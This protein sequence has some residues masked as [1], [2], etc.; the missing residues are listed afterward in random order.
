MSDLIDKQLAINEV[1]STHGIDDMLYVDEIINILEDLPCVEQEEH[2]AKV[3]KH[4]YAHVLTEEY[5]TDEYYVREYLCGF[6]KKK[7][8]GGDDY[9]S[10]CGTRLDWSDYE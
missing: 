1:W 5:S 9:C 10:H 7:V 8:L 6:C 3:I 2:T 4:E